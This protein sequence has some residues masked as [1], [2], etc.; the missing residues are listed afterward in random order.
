M[1]CG[2]ICEISQISRNLSLNGDM[3]A[4]FRHDSQF[5]PFQF[6]CKV[7]ET[8]TILPEV[9]LNCKLIYICAIC[10]RQKEITII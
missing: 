8:E 6:P 2:K 9:Q 1:Q 3:T 4:A 5:Q 7:S 10:F